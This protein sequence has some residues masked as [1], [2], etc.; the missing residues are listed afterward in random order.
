MFVG[1]RALRPEEVGKFEVVYSPEAIKG[2]VLDARV[3]GAGEI[4]EGAEHQGSP[5][6][7]MVVSQADI[8]PQW[9]CALLKSSLSWFAP[10]VP[11]NSDKR[12][13]YDIGPEAA[14]VQ[15]LLAAATPSGAAG[16]SHSGAAEPSRPPPPPPAAAAAP[17]T[18]RFK[19]EA[20]SFAEGAAGTSAAVAAASPM[21]GDDGVPSAVEQQQREAAAAADQQRLRRDVQ[22]KLAAY[23]LN[24]EKDAYADAFVENGTM[25]SFSGCSS[26]RR[27]RCSTTAA[28]TSRA[29]APSSSTT[30]S[31]SAPRPY[32]WSVSVWWLGVDSAR[33]RVQRMYKFI[34]IY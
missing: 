31:L 9:D 1:A 10:R 29:T 33:A 11:R 17:D 4:I 34:A 8:R 26:T 19:R 23:K 14:A 6:E 32:Q 12:L 5:L 22:E 20:P 21:R 30:S 13:K 16:P 25:T 27:W 7:R 28:L 2:D 18:K 24:D 3:G 15:K